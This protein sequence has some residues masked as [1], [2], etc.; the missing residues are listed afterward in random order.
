M[1][2]SKPK[3]KL[4]TALIISGIFSGNPFCPFPCYLLSA[5]DNF[6]KSQKQCQMQAAKIKRRIYK[7]W[8]PSIFNTY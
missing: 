6:Y 7:K 1:E 2:P 8:Q 4:I 5:S 3:K